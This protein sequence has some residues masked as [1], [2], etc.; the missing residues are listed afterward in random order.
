MAEFCVYKHTAP[1]GKVYIGITSQNPAS[2]WN[3]G[4]GYRGN[5]YFFKAIQK[6]GWN[7][8]RHD[9]LLEGLSKKDA[10]RLEI[11]LIEEY[12]SNNAAFGYNISKGG[13][14]GTHGAKLSEST[15]KKMSESRKG[16]RNPFYGRHHTP[17]AI[18]KNRTAHIGK[19]GWLKG[20]HL[21]E[22]HR[23]KV[24]ENHADLSG[25]NH[26]AAIKVICIETGVVYDAI[27]TASRATAVCAESIRKACHR[28]LKTA[29]GYHW[30]FASRRGEDDKGC[31]Q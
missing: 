13:E 3:S 18:E 9:I 30:E 4:Y 21:S 14:C 16:E 6:Y 17:E 26:G 11:E 24:S 19:K 22:E 2:R 25:G 15:R 20:K 8:I 7:N 10:C 1:N 28:K 31:C 12:Q 23:R 5:E 27:S 29:G